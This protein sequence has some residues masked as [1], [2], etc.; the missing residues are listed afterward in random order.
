MGDGT[1]GQAVMMALAFSYKFSRRGLTLYNTTLDGPMRT[2]QVG[3]RS[4]CMRHIKLAVLH[5]SEPGL[6]DSEA[7]MLYGHSNT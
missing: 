6:E 3:G 4:L 1:G 7:A 2:G 5:F